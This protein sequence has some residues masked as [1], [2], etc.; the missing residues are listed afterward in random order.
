M[1][2]TTTVHTDSASTGVEDARPADT[3]DGNNPRSSWNIGGD[4]VTQN[5]AHMAEEDR[6]ALR[7]F[8]FYCIESEIS[9][10][11]AAKHVGVDHST[12]HRVYRGRY[13]DDG[14]KK[15]VPAKLIRNII[16][17]R[18]EIEQHVKRD[19]VAFVLTPT[20]RKIH[21]ICELCAESNRIGSIYGPSQTGKTTALKEYQAA[22]NHGRTKY[23]RIEPASG[24]HEL[25]R[26]LAIQCAI[27]P[28]TGF[29]NLKRRI[30]KAIDKD[31]L[32]LI[33]EIHELTFTYK[34]RSK[35]SCVEL[36]R[37]LHD[38]TGCGMVL[39]G[40]NIWRDELADGKDK[41]LL[42]QME[43]RGIFQLQLPPCPTDGDLRAIFKSV[44]LDWPQGETLEIVRDVNKTR[45]LTA[46]T[47]F[48]RFG[49]KIAKKQGKAF[50]WEHFTKAYGIIAGLKSGKE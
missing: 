28:K 12:L 34:N 10:T 20:A 15:I 25:M 24:T 19:G 32:L 39:I 4:E 8:F 38:M 47:E 31:N 1:L 40:T 17:F 36:L 9:S 48:I 6:E 7:W 13:V 16:D 42:E 3:N 30:V 50:G 5:T 44:D 33:D 26:Q 35:L 2:T 37:W 27:S 45:G 18:K 46:L 14:G 43:R 23:I 22:H 29:D 11:E 21:Q 49:K 41:H